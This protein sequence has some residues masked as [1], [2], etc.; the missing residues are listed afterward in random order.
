MMR[1]IV[2]AWILLSASVVLADDFF[3]EKV[4]PILRTH[5]FECHSHGGT[6]E[7]GLSLDSRSGWEKGGDSGPA[8][9]PGKPADSLLIEKS[10][11]ARETLELA[12]MVDTFAPLF[13]T[14]EAMAIEDPGYYRSW[15]E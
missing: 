15:V 14:E 4:E 1:L 2:A 6:I 9:V 5:C 3:A 11:G 13:L 12:V 7:A 8:V 10:I